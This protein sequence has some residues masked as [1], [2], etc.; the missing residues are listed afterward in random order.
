MRRRWAEDLGRGDGSADSGL[1]LAPE[2]V[3]EVGL[4]QLGVSRRTG[5]PHVAPARHQG[6]DGAPQ[7]FVGGTALGVSIAG[8]DDL[9]AG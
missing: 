8:N 6:L 5:Q 7:P 1:A 2:H 4:A 9:G 3:V